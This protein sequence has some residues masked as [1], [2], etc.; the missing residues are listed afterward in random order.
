MDALRD[1]LSS[2]RL[3]GGVVVDARLAGDW[4]IISQ[5]TPQHCAKYFPVPGTL[6]AYHYVR[7][8]ELWAEVDGQPP[9]HAR[10]GSVL[11]FPSNDRHL[12]YSR[13]GLRPVDADDLLKPGVDGGPATIQIDG[14]GSGTE[15]FCGFLG[16]SG[17][18][19]PLTDCLPPMLLLDDGDATRDWVASSMRFLSDQSPEMVAQIAEGFVSHAIRRHLET[20]ARDAGGWIG[21][22]KDPAVGR[23]LTIIHRRFAED[24]DLEGLAR[25]A[26]VSRSVLGERFTTFIGEP[27][28]RYFARWRMRM[29]ANMLR[30]RRENTANIAYSVG[31]NSEAAFNRAFKREFGEPPATWRRRQEAEEAKAKLLDRELPPQ[32]VRYCEAADG[33][34]LAWSKVGEG[35]PLV[36]TANWLN[37]LEFDF[38][39]PIW[40]GWIR[41][42]SLD[43]TLIRYD[44]RGN[45]LSDWN[46]PD[47]C[48][49]AFVDDL[50]AVVDAAE[51]ERFDLL[52]IS[53]GAAVAI[54]Y[55]I[56]HPERVRRLVLLGGYAAGWR[57]RGDNE[58]IVRREAM[59]TLTEL[60]WG[61]DS[62]AYRQLFTSFYIPGADSRQ[63]SWFN[64]LQRR[65]TSPEVA[66]KLMRAL[67]SIDVRSLLGMVRHPTLV[68]HARGDQAVPFAQGETLARQIAGARFVPL[69]SDNHI[70]LEDEPAFRRF[71]DETKEFLGEASSPSGTMVEEAIGGRAGAE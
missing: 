55:S 36:K 22:L 50:A 21:G 9:V 4:C 33:T 23:A 64:E 14:K 66:A 48:L 70:L 16:V 35:P 44:E 40:R 30:E 11:V 28:M 62:P 61:K 52:G 39:S 69:D 27:P 46:A 12:L 71:I 54:A 29:A 5:F 42:L 60:G 65:S 6:I 15:L 56:L 63:M 18:R 41:E 49:D 3:S 58:E 67:S 26:G 20:S 47:L 53:Q 17:Q 51:V 8:G 19:H 68:L 13:S 32:E 34:K 1:I 37:H 2:L 31:F 57:A 24:L 7:A 59:L 25:E 38:E 45:G 10:Q 43:F